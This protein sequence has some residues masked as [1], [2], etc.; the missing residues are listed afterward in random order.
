MKKIIVLTILV[1]ASVAFAKSL[2]VPWFVD[3]AGPAVKFPPTAGTS[4]LIYLHNNEANDLLCTIGYITQAG[5]SIGPDAPDNTFV[6]PALATLAFR[7]ATN[8]PATVA[9]GMEAPAAILIPDRPMGT[10][11]GNDNN[12]NGS[13]FVSWV[14]G[15]EPLQGKSSGSVQGMLTQ[16]QAIG[17][18][19]ASGQPAAYGLWGTLLPPGV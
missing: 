15:T 6:I 4:A 16:A 5:V 7:P 9:G 12:T 11:N 14:V 1:V 17:A 13:L 8:D 2:T 10:A 18:R 19:A 3:N